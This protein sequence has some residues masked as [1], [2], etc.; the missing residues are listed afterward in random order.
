MRSRRVA[1]AIALVVL[2][3]GAAAAA[4]FVWQRQQKPQTRERTITA[5]WQA[6]GPSVRPR[7]E[8]CI[9]CHDAHP[10]AE[11][12]IAKHA[13]ATYGCTSC[14]GGEGTLESPHPRVALKD[15]PDG[16]SKAWVLEGIEPL[17][18]REP[19][20]RLGAPLPELPPSSPP[21]TV[22]ET[23]RDTFLRAV[24]EV[25]GG[26]FKC[27]TADE[28]LPGA[29]EL[30]RGRTLFRDLGCQACHAVARLA[31][32]PKP[33]A[34]LTDIAQRMLPGR[35]LAYLRDPKAVDP[36]ARMPASWPAGTDDAVRRDDTIAITA[37]LFER[38]ERRAREAKGQEVARAAVVAGASVEEGKLFYDAYG[39]KGCHDDAPAPRSLAPSLATAGDAWTEDWLAAYS[40][41]P[42]AL[43][44]ATRMP[45][46]RLSP[47]EAASIAKYLASRHG[48]GRAPPEDV[49]A[50]TDA[51]RRAERV[52]CSAGAGSGPMSRTQC[53]ELLFIRNACVACHDVEGLEAPGAAGP[54]L[55]GFATRARLSGRATLAK[56]DAPRM[57]DPNARMPDHDLSLEE[58]RALMVFLA[59]LGDAQPALGFDVAERPERRARETGRGLLRTLGCPGCHTAGR[60]RGVPSLVG[61]GARAR[62]EWVFAMLEHPE[63]NGVRPELHPE[64]VYGDLVPAAKLAPRM[65][66]F[67]LPPVDTTTIARLFTIESSASFP[68]A[69][70]RPLPL[71]PAERVLATTTLNAQCLSCHYV[72]ELPRERAKTAEHLAAGLSG[73]HLRRRDAWLRAFL[74]G[75]V[76]APLPP[77]LADFVLLLREGTVLPRPGEEARVPVLGLGE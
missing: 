7:R 72:G 14:H 63:R 2:L 57:G 10:K 49:L 38:S 53:G 22:A 24:P 17:E 73:V 8:S 64:W 71:T 77:K 15:A 59:G 58:L 11:G 29:P 21:W 54:A 34:P 9:T 13:T 25:Q 35:V 23:S 44:P 28:A 16:K 1:V 36:G 4:F 43:H 20:L 48:S 68:F 51:A 65:P 66:S 39:C 55:D 76:K 45:S 6:D 42:K 61:E 41:D 32:L 50:V 19:L 37:F 27:H 74:P 33:G 60:M 47:R 67:E 5:F 18:R 31:P 52:T 70:P 46:L 3:L 40:R 69:P 30:A 62:P 56:L 75:H 26:C 12:L